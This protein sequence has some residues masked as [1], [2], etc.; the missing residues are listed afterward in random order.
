[1]PEGRKRA[2]GF[3]G[4][5]VFPGCRAAALSAWRLGSDARS[6]CA[7][8]EKHALEGPDRPDRSGKRRRHD[9]GDSKCDAKLKLAVSSRAV[10][11]SPRKQGGI[12]HT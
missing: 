8:V 7:S 4:A 3:R 9:P 6:S 2:C 12:L 5:P 10:T 11:S 1:M